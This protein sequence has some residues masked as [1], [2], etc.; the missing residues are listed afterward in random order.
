M[1]LGL[2]QVLLRQR[3]STLSEQQVEMVQRI[4]NNGNQLLATIDDL[5]YFAKVETGCLSFQ[6]EEFNL[7][8]MVAKTIAEHLWLAEQK[9]LNLSCHVNLA[10]PLMVNDSVRLKQVLVKL[11]LNAIKFTKTG[12]IKV[13]AWES[14]DKIAIAVIDT[15]IGIAEPD[16]EHIFEQFRQVDQTTT[17]NYGGTGLGLAITKSLVEIMQGII[18]VKSKLGQGSTFKIELPRIVSG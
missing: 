5:L 7:T 1:I 9:H 6:V 10:H 4:L 15:G 13:K 2:S 14:G 18:T 16:L 3:T 11:L 17:R 8:T 12:S